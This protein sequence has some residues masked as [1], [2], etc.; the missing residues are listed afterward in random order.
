MY[1]R[2]PFT[3]Q[4]I[5]HTSYTV[6]TYRL[7]RLLDVKLVSLLP[8]NKRVVTLRGISVG[9]SVKPKFEQSTIS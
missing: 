4:S 2:T 6:V 7:P 8:R 1:V 5:M 3:R 9:Y